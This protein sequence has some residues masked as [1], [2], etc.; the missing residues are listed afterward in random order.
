MN[1]LKKWDKVQVEWIDSC[2]GSGWN[3]EDEFK[4]ENEKWLS[5]ES[6]GYF[7]SKNKKSLTIVQNKQCQP[8]STGH[9]SVDNYIQIP[10]VAITKTKKLK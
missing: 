9:H 4:Q 8:K 5:I 3:H 2:G 6:V 1:R 10:L 7:L